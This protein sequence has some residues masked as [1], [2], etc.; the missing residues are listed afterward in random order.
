MTSLVDVAVD[1]TIP[2]AVRTR[3]PLKIIPKPESDARSIIYNDGP[4]TIFIRGEKQ[5]VS[6]DCGNCGS[7]L[8]IDVEEW[9]VKNIVFRCSNCGAY[10]ESPA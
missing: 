1:V 2:R 9:Q 8:L 6:Y 10:N 4:G 3:V 5:G 7:P